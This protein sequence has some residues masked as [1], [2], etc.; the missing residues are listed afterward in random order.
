M[1]WLAERLAGEGC[2]VVTVT[3]PGSGIGPSG[4][5]TELEALASSTHSRELD[6]V[7]RLVDEI[8]EGSLLPRK[9]GRL[10]LLGHGRGGAHA[11]LHAVDDERVATVVSWAAPSALDRWSE[12]TRE[13]W[14]REGRL[15]V[16]EPR[17][18]RQLPL[19]RAVLDD[20]EAAG[21]RLDPLVAAGRFERPW[22]LVHG[23]DDEVVDVAEAR[24]LAARAS[25]A[26]LVLVER[27]DHHFGATE[28]VT[29]A[30]T[31]LRR[32]LQATVDHLRRT[33]P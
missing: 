27:A 2:C 21:D 29:T 7:A 22:L 13:T 28:P 19:D 10:V 20:V 5:H 6:E 31:A 25:R 14:R 11:L 26:R 8:Q 15:H 16:P 3:S 30:S 33:A 24:E 17:S 9:P 4:T 18:G 32:A 23:R 1:P 12:A